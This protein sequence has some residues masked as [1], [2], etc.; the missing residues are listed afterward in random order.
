MVPGTQLDQQ[1]CTGTLLPGEKVKSEE[2]KDLHDGY[3]DSIDT[4]MFTCISGIK[5]GNTQF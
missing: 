3:L 2:L 1:Y 5:L 4:F